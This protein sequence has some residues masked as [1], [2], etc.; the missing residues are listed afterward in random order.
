[1]N[2]PNTQRM[3]ASITATRIW[4]TLLNLR[5]QPF[6]FDKYF[7]FEIIGGWQGPAWFEL[8]RN[9]KGW[10]NDGLCFS[11]LIPSPRT[12]TEACELYHP[13]PLDGSHTVL[14]FHFPAPRKPT[15]SN[16]AYTVVADLTTTVSRVCRAAPPSPVEVGLTWGGVGGVLL[17]DLRPCPLYVSGKVQRIIVPVGVRTGF[18]N[19]KSGVLPDPLKCWAVP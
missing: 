17:F 18:P 7:S 5:F 16:F 6:I 13:R 10:V 3:F 14:W 19:H 15:A 8:E 11:I 9:R 12:S 2:C 4:L 1:M